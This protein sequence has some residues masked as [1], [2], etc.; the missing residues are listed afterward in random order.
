MVPKGAFRVKKPLYHKNYT[1]VFSYTFLHIFL[2]YKIISNEG[3]HLPGVK[4]L[5]CLKG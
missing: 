2:L 1:F 3:L 4:L 5:L